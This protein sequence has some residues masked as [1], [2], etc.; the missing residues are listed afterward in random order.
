VSTLSVV[1]VLETIEMPNFSSII[2][3]FRDLSTAP[4]KTVAEHQKIITG[5]GFVWWGWWNKQGERVP[6]DAF[7][8]I[9]QLSKTS[10]LDI[11]LFDTGRNQLLRAKLSEIVWD[12]Q[13]SR[14]GSPDRAVTPNYYGD[15]QY[16]AWFKL[17]QIDSATQPEGELKKWSYVQVSEMFETRKSVFEAFYDKQVSSFA[18]LRSQ[19]RT[20]W[21]IRPY[22][23]TDA[24]HEILVYDQSKSAPRNYSE[25]IVRAHSNNLLWISDPH[26]STD[27]HDFPRDPGQS[28]LNLSEAIRQDLESQHITSIGGLLI[29]GDLTWRAAREEFQWAAKFI[30]DIKSWSTLAP[31]Q[32]LVCPGNHDL[33][34]SSEPW[35]NGTL[36]AEV[37]PASSA[38]FKNFYSELFSVPSTESMSS[39]RHFWLP[40]GQMVD[41]VSLNSSLL[42]QL[43]EAFQ[44]Q[45][46]VGGEQLIE[47]AEGMKWSKDRS[48]GRAYRICM[49]HHHVVPILHREHPKHGHA[50][51]VV[52]D[53]GAL[54]RWLA[55]NEVDL[56]LHGHM[57]LP[58]VVKHTSA[59]DYPELRVWHEV[60]IA[61]LGSSGVTKDHRPNV[62]NSYGLIEFDREGVRIKV[63]TI[64]ADDAIPRAQR[65]V[66]SVLLPYRTHA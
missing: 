50:A 34:F 49:I 5:N 30:Q 12:S 20:I 27:H 44:G 63:R 18:E 17:T 42:Q 8:E 29:S 1:P 38:D 37:K 35:T 57:H 6:E 2:L 64:S 65:E 15:S 56:V 19:D 54:I 24:V 48:R 60:T 46:F 28:K 13:L 32:I 58:S 14:I 45:G 4:G 11:F 16:Y 3:R 23:A 43:P 62:P 26:F 61:A 59:L 51:S 40:D 31:S 36:A 25:E 10:P 22:R 21:F 47:A 52:H 9:N 41:I 66:Y 39:G 55:E 7:R 53:A 33:A